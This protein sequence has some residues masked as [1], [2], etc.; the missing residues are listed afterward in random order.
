MSEVKDR[1]LAA[2]KKELTMVLKKHR[3][4]QDDTAGQLML[5]ANSGGVSKIVWMNLE[6]K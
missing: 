1:D 5:H 3:I 2:C 6:V 4:F